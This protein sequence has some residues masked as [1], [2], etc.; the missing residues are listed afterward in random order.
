MKRFRTPLVIAA[1]LAILGAGIAG[2]WSLGVV[3]SEAVPQIRVET[4]TGSVEMRSAGGDWQVVGTSRE[5]KMGDEIRTGSDGKAHIRWG[6]RGETR[7]DPGTTLT[8]EEAPASAEQV[9]K[10]AVRL[11]LE[12]GRAWSRVLKLL[13]VDSGF[14]VRTDAVVATVRGTSF[15]TIATAEGAELAVTESVVAAIP[16]AG[17]DETLLRDNQW[18]SFSATGTPLMMRDLLPTDEWAQGNRALDAAFDEALRK[19]ID[20][21]LKKLG[22]NGPDWLV[23]LSEDLHYALASNSEKQNLAAE[24][25]A[26]RLARAIESPEDAERILSIDPKLLNVE[27]PARERM[28]SD[29][30]LALFLNQSRPNALTNRLRG[31]LTDLIVE[32]P[33]DEMYLVG[34]F[35]DDEIDAFLLN[36]Q[37][38]ERERLFAEILAWEQTFPLDL[39]SADVDGLHRK[40]QALRRRLEVPVDVVLT[41]EEVEEPTEEVTEP[42]PTKPGTQTP[43][44]E[45]PP[46]TNPTTEACSHTSFT[47]YANP[48]SVAVGEPATLSMYGSCANGTTDTLSASFAPAG[49]GDG[50]V[51]GNVFTPSR[52][53]TITLIGTAYEKGVAKT[54][55]TT[56][57]V[58]AQTQGSKLEGVTVTTP[59]PTALL[60]GQSAS[61]NARAYYVDGTSQDVTYQ[62]AWSTSNARLATVSNQR[63]Y[64]G[65]GEG[66]VQ[67]ICSHTENGKTVT[68]SLTFTI[69]YD[70][71]VSTGKPNPNG[72][73]TSFVN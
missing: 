35:I 42:E 33:T 21:R 28:I 68:G 57:T 19:E 45:K 16:T 13:D 1:V 5:I 11:R 7:L 62:C 70:T 55:K 39:N 18:G 23:D 31:L 48:S 37:P 30:R 40:A 15:G 63:L 50:S 26:R 44:P 9:T 22:S 6:D 2:F 64:T 12:S 61:L 34:L 20:E 27:G 17:G 52:A 60:V 36:P 73:P 58:R 8:V 69:K 66:T 3:A 51:S 38:G 32:E 56:I 46:V 24:Y 71:P 54:A 53:G 4:I 49:S 65:T 59:G 29:L 14:E 47:M 67:A 43:K 10:V 41:S 72:A 25:L